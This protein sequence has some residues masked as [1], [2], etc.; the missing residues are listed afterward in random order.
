MLPSKRILKPRSVNFVPLAMSTWMALSLS[1]GPV[2][3]AAAPTEGPELTASEVPQQ[4]DP[5][6]EAPPEISVEAE[7][8]TALAKQTMTVSETPDAGPQ[9]KQLSRVVGLGASVGPAYAGSDVTKVSPLPYID[10]RGLLGGHVYISDVNGLGLNLLDTGSFRAGLNANVAGGRDSNIDAHLRGLPDIGKA[11]VVGGFMAYW[12]EP[13]A[14]QASLARRIGSHPGTGA[15][16]GTTYS[17]S[18]LPNVQLP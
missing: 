4:P 2:A 8:Q 17:V 11:G 16:L 12:T 14:F 7:R 5:Q 15:S 18:P 9:S 13:F 1:H 10:V 3:L 6:Q